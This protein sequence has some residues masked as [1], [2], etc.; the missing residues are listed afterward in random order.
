MGVV[1]AQI[2]PHSLG[3]PRKLEQKEYLNN[4]TGNSEK[5]LR[6][7]SLCHT[8]S[9]SSVIQRQVQIFP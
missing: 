8:P 7:N 6:A 9:A 2:Q 3:I 4:C 1:A 5:G